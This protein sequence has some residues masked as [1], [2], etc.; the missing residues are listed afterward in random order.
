MVRA[1]KG[2]ISPLKFEFDQSSAGFGVPEANIMTKPKL[3]NVTT[4]K[5]IEQYR[6]N[7]K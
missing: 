7:I 4:A 3:R 6:K 2:E 1:Y 5:K